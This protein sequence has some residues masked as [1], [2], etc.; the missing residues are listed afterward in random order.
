VG[1]LDLW[2]L[3]QADLLTGYSWRLNR[4]V[5]YLNQTASDFE[6]VETALTNQL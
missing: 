2:N 4:C 6:A 3:I 5:N 1:F